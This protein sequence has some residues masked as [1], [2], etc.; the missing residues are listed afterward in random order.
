MSWGSG[1]H[2]RAERR[3]AGMK[4]RVRRAILLIFDTIGHL[5]A[6]A[7][8][9]GV[10][11]DTSQIGVVVVQMLLG[12]RV[13]GTTVHTVHSRAVF[14]GRNVA[15]GV[16][17]SQLGHA[18][19][20]AGKAGALMLWAEVELN[21]AA[22]VG[23]GLG[24]GCVAIA[25]GLAVV[26]LVNLG[27]FAQGVS[28]QRLLRLTVTIALP[29]IGLGFRAGG[30]GKS[31]IKRSGGGR[32]FRTITSTISSHQNG[33]LVSRVAHLEVGLVVRGSDG[34]VLLILFAKEV[35]C[36]VDV[37][38]YGSQVRQVVTPTKI[39]AGDWHRHAVV[40]WWVSYGHIFHERLF[41]GRWE[42]ED[43]RVRIGGAGHG[44]SNRA[45]K[46]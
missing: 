45:S 29:S 27:G 23:H 14:E 21:G 15:G 32:E 18:V 20:H 39:Q 4:S 22:I 41:D 36:S 34:V 13:V 5:T 38:Q 46:R 43:R 24:R 16:G 6:V 40:P 28:R 11:R 17:L 33:E 25:V 44:K 9:H 42:C 10:E 8:V 3:R 7:V 19:S 37:A 26:V 30:L 12:M 35:A 1:S 2:G 31:Q